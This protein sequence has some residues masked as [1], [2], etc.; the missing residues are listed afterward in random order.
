MKIIKGKNN[1]TFVL[2]ARNNDKMSVIEVNSN[3]KK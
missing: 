1:K 3:E 2:L